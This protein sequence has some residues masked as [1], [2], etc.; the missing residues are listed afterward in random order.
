M[1]VDQESGYR[2]SCV[3]GE[4]GVSGCW[5]SR[6]LPATVRVAEAAT[7]PM[8][9]SSSTSL[10][11]ATKWSGPHTDPMECGDRHPEG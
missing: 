10:T 5:T 7:L 3:D 2:E 1:C 9:L 6:C 11:R 8:N 4:L